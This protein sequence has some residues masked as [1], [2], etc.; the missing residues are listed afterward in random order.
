MYHLSTKYW[1]SLWWK[2]TVSSIYVYPFI[3]NCLNLVKNSLCGGRISASEWVCGKGHTKPSI[4]GQPW[5]Q[6]GGEKKADSCGSP[7]RLE[8][9]NGWGAN[10]KT[11]PLSL[12]KLMSKTKMEFS[13][14]SFKVFIAANEYTYWAFSIFCLFTLFV[15]FNPWLYKNLALA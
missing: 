14:V 10:G 15:L 8:R 7:P 6:P 9:K 11:Q 2:S 1:L 13:L 4:T 5:P 3:A 12:P